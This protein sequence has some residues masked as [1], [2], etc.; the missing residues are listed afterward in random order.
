MSASHREFES[1]MKPAP[2]GL[3]REFE[4]PEAPTLWFHVKAA[5]L[6]MMKLQKRAKVVGPMMFA[7]M[8]GI[9]IGV[10]SIPMLAKNILGAVAGAL[11]VWVV[12]AYLSQK[13]YTN[14][15][16]SRVR[17]DHQVTVKEE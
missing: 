10:S 14:R 12:L 1:Q 8:V 11:F 7:L 16:Y 5:Q 2:R 15:L 6:K 17:P 13:R 9:G 3:L 4:G